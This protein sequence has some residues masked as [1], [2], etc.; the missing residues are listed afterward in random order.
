[1]FR[2]Q[3][4]KFV[5]SRFTTMADFWLTPDHIAA[6]HALDRGQGLGVS[7]W[8]ALPLERAGYIMPA[9]TIAKRTPPFL[10]TRAGRALLDEVH[11]GKHV[12]LRLDRPARPTRTSYSTP[13]SA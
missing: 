8:V 6:L 1:M 7:M 13:A 11:R 12:G 3:N 5:H 9:V 4:H 10:L 2:E